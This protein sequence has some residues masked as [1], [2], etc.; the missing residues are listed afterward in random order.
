M[1]ESGDR[2]RISE[3]TQEPETQVSNP[4]RF[5]L[6]LPNGEVISMPKIPLFF[7]EEQTHGTQ[8]PKASLIQENNGMSRKHRKRL[9]KQKKKR[10]YHHVDTNTEQTGQNM[11]S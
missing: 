10:S 3:N 2:G 6:E 5:N 7:I 11:L 8:P 1:G 4:S 9:E